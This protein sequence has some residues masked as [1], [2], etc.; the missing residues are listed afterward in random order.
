MF[1]SLMFA[2]VRSGT[3]ATSKAPC[4]PLHQL[5]KSLGQLDRTRPVAVHCKGGYRSAIAASLIQRA[6]LKH[7]ARDWRVRR[8]ARAT[9]S[10]SGSWS[11]SAA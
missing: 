2:V 1:R 7:V 8:V 9:R 3:K 4:M 6:G 11:F 5:S 10:A